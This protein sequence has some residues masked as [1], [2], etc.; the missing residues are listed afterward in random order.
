MGVL[1]KI[2]TE[3]RVDQ[4][5]ALILERLKQ[6]I[7]SDDQLADPDR[8]VAW[9]VYVEL[10]TRITTQKLRYHD[11]DESSALQSLYTMFSPCRELL[12]TYGADCRRT[13]ALVTYMLNHVLRPVTSEW[14]RRKLAGDF[15]RD[16]AC[17][18]F[19][20]QLEEVRG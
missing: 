1:S 13:A 4:D 6:F 10:R 19:R 18:D 7:P 17:R 2:V 11:G 14:H 12:R 16:D 20:A 9:E 15:A 8:T 5:A 3:L